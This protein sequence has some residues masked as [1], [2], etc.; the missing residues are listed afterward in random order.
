[1]KPKKHNDLSRAKVNPLSRTISMIGCYE[2]VVARFKHRQLFKWRVFTSINWDRPPDW[3]STLFSDR[4]NEYL[5]E[6]FPNKADKIHQD[7]RT[8]LMWF[9]DDDE[10][11]NA[12][13]SYIEPL[14]LLIKLEGNYE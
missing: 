2:V 5:V 12:F 4:M 11:K 1:M 3:P 14:Q 9:I 6:K 7:S 8:N 10:V 13:I